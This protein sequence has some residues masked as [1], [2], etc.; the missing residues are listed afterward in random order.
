MR[1][2]SGQIYGKQ[3]VVILE[4]REGV[5]RYNERPLGL[6]CISM[7]Y[8]ITTTRVPRNN[9]EQQFAEVLFSNVYKGRLK[10]SNAAK[11]KVTSINI[12]KTV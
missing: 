12:C 5:W 1:K 3:E 4:A 9:R 11:V 7:W 2:R 6:C 10:F 8:G